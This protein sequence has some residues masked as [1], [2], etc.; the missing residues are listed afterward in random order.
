MKDLSGEILQALVKAPHGRKQQALK[1]L[2]G[3][4][5]PEPNRDEP[6]LYSVSQAARVLGVSRTTLWRMCQSGHLSKVPVMSGTYRVRRA[7]IEAIARDGVLDP[8]GGA[9]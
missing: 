8:K 2:R 9:S 4:V 3:E 6:L 7:D 1:L 5:S